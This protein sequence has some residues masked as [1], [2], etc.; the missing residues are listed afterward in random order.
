M[1][2]TSYKILSVNL[3]LCVADPAECNMNV[4]SLV[5]FVDLQ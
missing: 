2:V 1:I 3:R 5:L 4:M